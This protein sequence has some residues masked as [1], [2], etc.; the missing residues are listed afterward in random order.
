M[1]KNV[2]DSKK[3]FKKCKNFTNKFETF[4]RVIGD[5]NW[6]V[7]IHQIYF[8]NQRIREKYRWVKIVL[9]NTHNRKNV[10]FKVHFSCSQIM[11]WH[12]WI[13]G[14]TNYNVSEK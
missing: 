7:I 8:I 12:G 2:R 6:M 10:G 3:I 1:H 11:Y 5:I 14:F 4:V 9:E 13:K